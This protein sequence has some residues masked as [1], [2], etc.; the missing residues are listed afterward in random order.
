MELMVLVQY[1]LRVEPLNPYLIFVTLILPSADVLQRQ[2]L[3]M[4]FTTI[5]MQK[6]SP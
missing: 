6:G 3:V 1:L 4:T 2:L 5:A